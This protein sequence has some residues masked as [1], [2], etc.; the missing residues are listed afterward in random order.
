[1]YTIWDKT[2]LVVKWTLFIW[3]GC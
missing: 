2:K 3:Y 1:M